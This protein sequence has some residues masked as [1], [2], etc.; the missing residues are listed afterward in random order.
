MRAAFPH[1]FDARPARVHFDTVLL[2]A[3]TSTI[4]G[5]IGSDIAVEV[6]SRA[7]KQVRGALVDLAFHPHT[8]KLMVLI[9]KYGNSYTAPQCRAILKKL[10]GECPFEVVEIAGS[11]DEPVRFLEADAKKVRDAVE[12]LRRPN[13]K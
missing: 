11:G 4:D 9:Q 2:N 8:K 7:S 12:R 13:L 3:G 10:C 5:V 6:E 1:E